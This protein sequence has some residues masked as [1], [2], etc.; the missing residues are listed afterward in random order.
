M[1]FEPTYDECSTCLLYERGNGKDMVSRCLVGDGHEPPRLCPVGKDRTA[2]TPKEIAEEIIKAA[3]EK[4][5]ELDL[6]SK[7][8]NIN[9]QVSD[10][11]AA[12]MEEERERERTEADLDSS[13]KVPS[14]INT[15]RDD[16]D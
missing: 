8:Y 5:W 15:P 4:G 6:V 1:S 3:R 9:R 10:K 16:N 13:I 7:V 2:M 14:S 12:F 11:L